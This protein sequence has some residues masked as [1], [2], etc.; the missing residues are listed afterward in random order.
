MQSKPFEKEWRKCAK[1][2]AG[3]ASGARPAALA[4]QGVFILPLSDA[5]PVLEVLGV[6]HGP[7]RPAALLIGPVRHAR[8]A[9]RVTALA[10]RRR[11]VFGMSGDMTT[12]LQVI[13]SSGTWWDRQSMVARSRRVGPHARVAADF[14]ILRDIDTRGFNGVA[15]WL[16]RRTPVL[17]MSP[18]EMARVAARGLAAPVACASATGDAV[19]GE[20]SSG[21]GLSGQ[22]GLGAVIAAAWPLWC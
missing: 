16:C 10:D 2:G 20:A 4:T 3:G 1:I 15:V 7:T 13:G 14:V 12:I 9:L 6:A 11:G 8:S 5:G 22:T 18:G 19:P 21:A 17:G